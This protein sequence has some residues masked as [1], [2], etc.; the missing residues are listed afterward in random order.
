MLFFH[1]VELKQIEDHFVR[2]CGSPE[3]FMNMEQFSGL[4]IELGFVPELCQQCYR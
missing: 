3:S 1:Y 2:H 4:L